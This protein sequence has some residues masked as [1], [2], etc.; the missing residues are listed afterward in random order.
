MVGLKWFK[1]I[2]I[3]FVTLAQFRK[4]CSKFKANT[5]KVIITGAK[6]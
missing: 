4:Y 2:L 1:L 6:F 5:H 3:E